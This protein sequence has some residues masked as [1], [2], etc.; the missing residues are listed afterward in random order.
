MS[1]APSAAKEMSCRNVSESPAA[2]YGG[3]SALWRTT[4]TAEHRA[5][6]RRLRI[7][8]RLV[9][10]LERLAPSPIP[11]P[12]VAMDPFS[13]VAV[14]A[15]T[16]MH[17]RLVSVGNPVLVDLVCHALTRTSEAPRTRL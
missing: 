3:L 11:R 2:L 13:K 1:S 16:P 9:D 8:E 15:I 12:C 10:R 17:A 7:G 5:R 6:S 4:A 14:G